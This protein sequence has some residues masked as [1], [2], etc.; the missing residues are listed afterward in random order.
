MTIL[1]HLPLTLPG[2]EGPR[3][4]QVVGLVPRTFTRL[5]RQVLRQTRN[6][7]LWPTAYPRRHPIIVVHPGHEAFCYATMVANEDP[8]RM[9][10]SLAQ[11]RL[12]ARMF[13]VGV[14]SGLRD[15]GISD[16]H[17][18]TL[19]LGHEAYHVNEMQRRQ[20]SR[21]SLAAASAPFDF[22]AAI[23]PDYTPEVIATIQ[24]LSLLPITRAADA[25]RLSRLHTKVVEGAADVFA[26]HMVQRLY[27]DDALRIG[28]ALA[29]ERQEAFWRSRR[30]GDP[31]GA[32]DSADCL[33]RLLG[34]PLLTWPHDQADCAAFAW[35]HAL[36][37]FRM[38]RV[39]QT[40]DGQELL[41]SLSQG[42]RSLPST[43][44]LPT[45]LEFDRRM[46]SHHEAIKLMRRRTL[47]SR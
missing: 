36:P 26:M 18:M 30:Q 9:G 39:M 21:V 45:L 13:E 34:T 37:F 22:T 3:K 17:L 40:P 7:R 32:Y 31:M 29:H 42:L 10:G 41:S 20:R 28:H 46:N 43:W 47:P 33:L 6:A 16:E 44:P 24:R 12:G 8:V 23:H 38:A 14:F 27:P 35:R 25:V 4:I 11:I 15:Q 2:G 1:D 19:V 5:V